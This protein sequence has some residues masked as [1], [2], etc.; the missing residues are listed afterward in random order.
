MQ[1]TAKYKMILSEI[2]MIAE[3]VKLFSGDLQSIVYKDL[4]EALI[5]ESADLNQ[6][7]QGDELQQA[8]LTS[9]DGDQVPDAFEST[10]LQYNRNNILLQLNDMEFSAFV[11][12]FY[13][14]IAPIDKRVNVIGTE[15]YIE[16]SRLVGREM[17]KRV[18][19]TLHN[20]KNL[21]GYLTKTG[22]DMFELSEAGKGFVQNTVIGERG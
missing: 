1:K 15:H 16:L 6:M 10:I 12:Y 20:A 13:T 11:A 3:K 21:R 7:R 8:T 17:P 9:E 19:G 2:D 5:G 18:S 4:M 22:R 14:E